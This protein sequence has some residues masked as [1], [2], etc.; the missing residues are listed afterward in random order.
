VTALIKAL[1]RADAKKNVAVVFVQY[2]R[3]LDDPVKE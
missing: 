2:T 3:A 1:R